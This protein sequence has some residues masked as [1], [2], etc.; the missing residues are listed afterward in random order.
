MVVGE[1]L[2][3]T[4]LPRTLGDE[5]LGRAY[6]LVVPASL[7]GIVAGSLLAGPLVAGLGVRGA[8]TA[9]G[10]FV[11]LAAGVLL[12]RPLRAAGGGTVVVAE[13]TP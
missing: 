11:F 6:G 12:W 1:V 3:E 9:A 7:G 4:A 10:V 2:S 8:L 5:V 13:A